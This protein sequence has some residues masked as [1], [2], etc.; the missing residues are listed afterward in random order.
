MVREDGCGEGGDE[1]GEGG[2]GCGEGG[3]SVVRDGC[4]VRMW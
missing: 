1:C 3:M 4:V 2:D